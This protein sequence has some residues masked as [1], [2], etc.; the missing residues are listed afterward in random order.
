MSLNENRR[1]LTIT[2]QQFIPQ[3]PMNNK[4]TLLQTMTWYRTG[5]RPLS[6][7]KV[8]TFVEL[9]HTWVTRPR[10]TKQE[11]FSYKIFFA[12]LSFEIATLLLYNLNCKQAADES[13]TRKTTCYGIFHCFLF[14]VVLFHILWVPVMT[15][16]IRT[17][18]YFSLRICTCV[19]AISRT[20]SKISNLAH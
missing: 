19:W 12:S 20:L 17:M 1:I 3:G 7:K 9:A 2:S 11:D 18:T 4:G 14:C 8:V 16:Y 6:D 5:N 15:A 10:W 13:K